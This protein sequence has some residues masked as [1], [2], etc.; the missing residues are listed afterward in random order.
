MK[1]AYVC[2]WNLSAK[3]GVSSKVETQVRYWRAAGNEVEVFSLAR[4]AELDPASAVDGRSF[5]FAGLRSRFAATKGLEEAVVGCGPDLV[6][7]RYD[8]FLPPL[9][10]LLAA[11]PTAVEINT[12]DRHEV[13]L[14]ELRS[15]TVRLYNELNR[16]RILGRAAGFVCVTHELARSSDV[17][18]FGKPTVVIANAIDLAQVTPHPS[19]PG[20]RPRLVFLGSRRQPWHGADKIVF[21]ARAMPEAEF[22]IA[23]YLP[24]DLGPDLPPNVRVHGVL[25][26]AEYEPLLARADVGIGTL[27]LHRK[28]MSEASPLKVREYLAHGLPVVLGYEDTDFLDEGPWFLLRLPNHEHNVEESLAAIREFVA[29]VRGHRVHRA[30]VADRIGADVK[31][32]RRLEFF[33]RLTGSPAA[34]SAYAEPSVSR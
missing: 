28:R 3:D 11:C 31:E 7:L 15:R 18:S 1:I 27:A 34:S 14:R 10:R 19:E 29:R 24:D 20:D 23:G 21:L 6:Y 25:S 26:S 33:E 16:R 32:R 30:E 9:P 4:A 2:Y 13:R 12:A 8:L 17:A 22:D 5:A